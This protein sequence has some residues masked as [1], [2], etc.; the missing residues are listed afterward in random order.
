[1]DTYTEAVQKLVEVLPQLISQPYDADLRLREHTLMVGISCNKLTLIILP[2]LKTML[3][4]V[5]F[6]D[7]I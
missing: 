5:T 6:M 1:M 2:I 7:S 3:R 4:C